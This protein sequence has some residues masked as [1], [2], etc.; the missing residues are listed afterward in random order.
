MP[1]SHMVAKSIVAV[2]IG[3]TALGGLAFWFAGMSVFDAINHAMSA[4]STGGFSTS[5]QSLAKWH[6]PAVHWVAVVVMIFGSMP[7][8]LYVATLRGN[9]KGADQGPAG[10]GPSGHAADLPGWYW[11]PGRQK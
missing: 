3:F 9:R 4:I 5:D 11:A 2:Y 8:A 1:R 7:F 10:P 6:Q